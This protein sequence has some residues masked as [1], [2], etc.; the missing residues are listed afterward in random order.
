MERFKKIVNIVVNIITVLLFILT[1]TVL[2]L[3]LKARSENK[4][5][6]I[7]GYTYSRVASDSME[8]NL[9]IGDIIFTKDVDFEDIKTDEDNGKVQTGD[10]IVFK[11]GDRYIVHRAIRTNEDGSIVTKGDK[12]GEDDEPVTE[13]I[14]VG[15]VVFKIPKLGKLVEKQNL[16]FTIIIIIFVIIIINE[17]KNIIKN[18]TDE[19]KAQLEKELNEK[20]NLNDEKKE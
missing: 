17:I 4:M 9:Y 14:Y 18:I 11:R 13:D 8:P 1:F 2:I 5:T 19:K 12:Y 20:Y 6:V 7:F 15:K 16:I 3:G 10:I